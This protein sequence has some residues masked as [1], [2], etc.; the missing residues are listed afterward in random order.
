MCLA[1]G[2]KAFQY[3]ELLWAYRVPLSPLLLLV[4]M[5]IL[6]VLGSEA[7]AVVLPTWNQQ[8][9]VV[10]VKAKKWENDSSFTVQETILF[11]SF[12][13]KGCTKMLKPWGNSI[14]IGPSWEIDVSPTSLCRPENTMSP[15]GQSL[16]HKQH[17]TH[18]PN[19]KQKTYPCFSSL[20][21]N[22]MKTHLFSVNHGF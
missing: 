11:I 22:G 2:S 4:L 6:L 16:W 5:P 10:E 3:L 18:W 12:V 21:G 17:E 8:R 15:A 1:D 13:M 19:K 20:R 14:R 7:W 9:E